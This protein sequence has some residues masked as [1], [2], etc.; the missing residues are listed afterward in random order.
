[1]NEMPSRPWQNVG[2]RLKGLLI[3]GGISLLA[4]LVG[5]LLFV[6]ASPS[7]QP[8]SLDCAPVLPQVAAAIDVDGCSGH[9]AVGWAGYE[10]D[11]TRNFLRFRETLQEEFSAGV[12]LIDSFHCRP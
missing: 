3:L 9:K 1:M 10:D 2:G 4:I 5:L 7:S 12:I 8:A 11:A 6:P